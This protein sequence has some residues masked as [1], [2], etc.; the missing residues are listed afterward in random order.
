MLILIVEDELLVA[1]A[2]EMSMRQAGH[3]VLG[4][5]DNVAD[6]LA[7]VDQIPPA[8]AL[9]DI[10]L[11]DG[12]NGTTVARSLHEVHGV[13]SLFL[14][15]DVAQARG[16]RHVAWGLIQKPYETPDVVRAV[17]FMEDVTAGRRPLKV[18]AHLEFWRPL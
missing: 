12:G 9:V 1:L 18:P 2:L 8:L 7:M 14:S 4:P 13:P 11:R 6:A 17:A 16:H 10:D 3:D 5:V 15:A